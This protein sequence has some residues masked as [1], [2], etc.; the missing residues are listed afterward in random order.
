MDANYMMDLC[1]FSGCSVGFRVVSCCYVAVPASV[2]SDLYLFV[3]YVELFPGQR[4]QG[5]FYKPDAFKNLF[6]K[7]EAFKNPPFA[8]LQLRQNYSYNLELQGGPG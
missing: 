5:L 3:I 6:Y 8:L 1:N 4:R 7:L 2:H